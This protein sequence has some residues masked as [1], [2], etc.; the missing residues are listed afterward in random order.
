MPDNIPT[1]SSFLYD[2]RWTQEIDSVVL[3]TLVRLKHA[4]G[5]DGT[6]FPSHFLVETKLAIETKFGNAFEWFDLVDRLHFLEKPYKTFNEIQRLEGT[7]WDE[8]N[9]KGYSYH[10]RGDPAYKQLYELFA[11]N[12]IKEEHEPT[13]IVLSESCQPGGQVAAGPGVMTPPR[14]TG[15]VNS[16]HQFSLA[17]RKLMFD[18]GSNVDRE[19]TN[20]KELS[21]CVPDAKGK[22]ER[23]VDKKGPRILPREFPPNSPNYALSCASNSPVPKWRMPCKPKI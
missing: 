2:S 7:S 6:L 14:D 1:Q 17:R 11:L 13:V 9:E 5:C 21:Y 20:K 18:E 8:C 16:D 10:E 19:S 3:G 15:E 4:S 22:L 23:K 12:V